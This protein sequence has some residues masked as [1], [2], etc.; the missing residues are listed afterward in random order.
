MTLVGLPPADERLS[1]S[2][3]G[4]NLYEKEIAGCYL[5]SSDPRRDFP[6]ILALE[7]AGLLDLKSMVTAVRPSP[8]S[9]SR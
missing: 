6:R 1:V 2:A 7:A 3:L 9:T 5:G 4:V 8:R